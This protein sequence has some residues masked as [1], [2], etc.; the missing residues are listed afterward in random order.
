MRWALLLV[1]FYRWGSWSTER[2]GNFSKV[3]QL[4]TGK[5]RIQAQGN[6]RQSPHFFKVF[7]FF[8]GVCVCLV[9]QSYLT[10]CHGDPVDYSLSGSSVCGIFQARILEWAAISF[11]RVSS[12]P[13]GWTWVSHVEGG[14]FI[15]WATREAPFKFYVYLNISCMGCRIL[16]PW[17]GIKPGPCL[18]AES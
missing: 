9:T 3:T 4:I 11:S 7:F 8:F 14:F 18:W 17:P 10:L 15:I 16:V 2:L 6:Q 5:V 13:R 12:W 1:S